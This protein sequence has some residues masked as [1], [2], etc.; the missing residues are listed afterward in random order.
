MT[1]EKKGHHLNVFLIK[2]AYTSI[3]QI[4]NVSSCQ[5]PI[6]VE[7]AGYGVGR[8]F[9]KR[10]PPAP[11]KWADLFKDDVDLNSLKV[12]GVSGVFVIEIKGRWFVLAFG[13][14]GRFLIKDDVYEER[15]GLLCAL[16]SVDPKTFRCVDVQSLDAIQ[17]HTRI[18]SGLEATPDQFGLDVEQDM[19]KAIVGTPLNPALGSRMTGSDSL[20]VNVKL[21]LSD[22]PLLLNEYRKQFEADLN[23]KDHQW[24]NNIYLVKSSL[25]IVELE[26]ILNANLAANDFKNVWLAIP[27]IIEWSTVKGFMYTGGLKEVHPDINLQG[28][29]KTVK[30]DTPL[31]LDLLRQRKVQCADADH[32][33]TFRKW[34]VLKC[35]Y[36]EIDYDGKKYILNDGKWFSVAP[37]FVSK[38]E[39]DFA[40]IPMSKLAMPSYQ[41]G[42]EGAYN[43]SVAATE[44]KHY[45][46]LDDTKKVMH[47]GGHGQVEICDLFSID[48]ELIHVKLYGK[49]SVF[50]HLF[51]QGF[52][53][54]QLIQIDADFRKKVRGQLAAPF[55]DLIEINKKPGQDE[56]TVVYAVISEEKGGTLRL[57]F[58]S[59]V[60]LNNTAKVLR[61]F[62]YR[63]ELLKIPVDDRYAKTT[64]LPPSKQKGK[65]V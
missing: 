2:A 43:A 21:D 64:K 60:N 23:S 29:L 24:V 52:V 32:N 56:F 58:F 59:R 5:A 55:V 18:Q 17:S 50:S 34:S 42:G 26:A 47:G 65:T 16:N 20:S 15:F 7:I 11:P 62:G 40:R 10:T 48:R 45:A 57:P 39:A 33:P 37:D 6:E 63:V 25:L 13:Q 38:T 44:P 35:L 49:S 30:P 31:S 22:L 41:G 1:T 36:A 54:A 28:F 27:E 9:I 8:L 53:S 14:G 51:S 3:D 46:L 4:V 12:P 61:G 19:L